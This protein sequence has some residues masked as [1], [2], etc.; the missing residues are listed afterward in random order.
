MS[1]SQ[2]QRIKNLANLYDND[3][4]LADLNETTHTLS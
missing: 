3:L 1:T 2:P 4:N